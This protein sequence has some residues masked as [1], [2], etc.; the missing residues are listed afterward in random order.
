MGKTNNSQLGNGAFFV[1]VDGRGAR[2]RRFREV[3][4]AYIEALNREPDQIVAS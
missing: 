1:G 4:T 3:M 2:P